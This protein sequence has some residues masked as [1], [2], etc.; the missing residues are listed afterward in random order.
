VSD[1]SGESAL[2]FTLEMADWRRQMVELY[3]IVRVMEDPESA[4]HY[5]R[6]TRDELFRT[7]A[8]SPLTPAEQDAFTANDY[9]GYDPAWRFTP[10]LQPLAEQQPFAIALAED[11]EMGLTAWASTVG[12]AAELGSEL[13]LY[14]VTG[15]AGG[16]FLPFRDANSGKTCFGGGRYLLDTIKGA[17]LGLNDDGKVILDFNFAYYPSCAYGVRWVCPLSPP[18]NHLGAAIDAGQRGLAE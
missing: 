7:H 8:A 13:T 17:D 5:W 15:Y 2:A 4:W 12:L 6:R 16:L 3:A 9:H 14:R 1:D 10:P 11:G 18:E